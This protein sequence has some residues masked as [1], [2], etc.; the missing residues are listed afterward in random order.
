MENINNLSRHQRIENF[1]KW[2][3]PLV[4]KEI[5]LSRRNNTK[6]NV[7]LNI[8]RGVENRNIEIDITRH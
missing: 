5:Y 6:K 2:G 4:S 1:Y 8:F 3:R 7:L